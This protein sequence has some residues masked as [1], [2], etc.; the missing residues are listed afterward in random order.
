MLTDFEFLT[1]MIALH[2]L[3]SKYAFGRLWMA[4]LTIRNIDE[5]LKESLTVSTKNLHDF[6]EFSSEVRN[7]FKSQENY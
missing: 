7:W 4:S 6:K 5:S 2:T 3:I 1:R